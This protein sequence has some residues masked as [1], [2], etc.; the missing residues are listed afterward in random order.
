MTLLQNPNPYSPG[1]SALQGTSA[2][3]SWPQ[4]KT[5]EPTIGGV[6]GHGIVPMGHDGA[7]ERSGVVGA[8]LRLMPC[9]LKRMFTLRHK[10]K[11]LQSRP[12]R[13]RSSWW[14]RQTWRVEGGRAGFTHGVPGEVGGY[15]R[16]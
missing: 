6:I 16:C 3:V 14:R 8:A 11:F 2:G 9:T 15:V 10:W 4:E 13:Q 7:S 5:A 1:P 12:N